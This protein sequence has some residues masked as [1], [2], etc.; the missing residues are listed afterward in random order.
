MIQRLREDCTNNCKRAKKRHR[1]SVEGLHDLAV[2]KYSQ[3]N[4]TNNYNIIIIC[5]D[6]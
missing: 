3:N 1:E 6:Y 2:K 4:N 5:Y